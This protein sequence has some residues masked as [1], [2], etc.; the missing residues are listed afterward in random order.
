MTEQTPQEQLK[1]KLDSLRWKLQNLQSEARLNSVR[2][3]VSDLD[4]KVNEL[5]QRVKSL[6]LKG[7]VFGKGLESRVQ[8]YL[9]RWNSMSPELKRQI[10]M[11]A[12]SLE[13][14]L[15]MISAQMRQIE[16]NAFNPS[17]GLPMAE[18]FEHSL[19]MFQDK[20]NAAEQ[21]IR[22][23]FDSFSGEITQ[24]SAEVDRIEWMLTQ[25]TEACFKLLAT[26]GGLM[27]V[28]ARWAR[29]ERMDNND[30]Q[31]VLYLT[32]QRIIFEQKEEVTTKKVLFI[33]TEKKKVQQ[34]MLEAPVGLV[35][36]VDAVKKGLFKNEDHLTITFKSGA[37][38]RSAW[39]HLDGQDCN[40]WQGLINQ[41]CSHDFDDEREVPVDQAAVEKVKQAPGKCPNCGA[42]INQ[43]VMRGMDSITCEYC[44]Y[45]IRL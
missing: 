7:Y 30:P 29:D 44:Q 22:T 27:A 9:Q 12:P 5:N 14:E 21:T 35:E 31:G 15:T 45:V 25:L 43:Q 4:T 36:K 20:V 24:T 6:R 40:M 26:E 37:P 10:D 32:D 11:Q 33:A 8:G 1:S 18:Q 41:A 16:A 19:G 34:M 2:D 39:F 23:S 38:V 17:M 13:M 42:P 3:Q 28:K